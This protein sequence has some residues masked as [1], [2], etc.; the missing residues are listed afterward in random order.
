MKDKPLTIVMVA[1]L[2]NGA[3]LTNW[4]SVNVDTEFWTA[5]PYT[6][7]IYDSDW[8]FDDT[9]RFAICSEEATSPRLTCDVQNLKVEYRLLTDYSR[10]PFSN[11][12]IV[13]E[14]SKPSYFLL[15]DILGDYK[16]DEGIGNTLS[17]A[18]GGSLGP[19]FLCKVLRL[20]PPRLTNYSCFYSS[21]LDISIILFYNS[22]QPSQFFHR[23]SV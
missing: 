22:N 10:F 16:I 2:T 13:K 4:C 1:D 8:V 17:V 20:F 7:E 3:S 14:S 5:S 21:S 23:I 12:G 18:P 11:T 19:A 6:G 9:T 15:V